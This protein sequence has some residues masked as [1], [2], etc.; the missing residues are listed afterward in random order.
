MDRSTVSQWSQLD[1]SHC[2]IRDIGCHHLSKAV[3]KLK[4]PLTLDTVN[5]SDNHLTIESVE[6]IA[7]FM[8]TCKTRVLH[9]SDNS[10]LDKDGDTNVAC[11]ALNYAFTGTCLNFPL[12]VYHHQCEYVIYNGKEDKLFLTHLSDKTRLI[13]GLFIFNY[14]LQDDDSLEIL[15]NVILKQQ[16]LSHLYFWN[17]SINRTNIK[18]IISFMQ[19]ENSYKVLF[20]YEKTLNESTTVL[21]NEIFTDTNIAYILLSAA[22]LIF[23]NCKNRHIEVTLFSN[24]L[25]P[26]CDQL[27]DVCLLNC[28]FSATTIKYVSTLWSQCHSLSRIILCNNNLDINNFKQIL[29]GLETLKSLKEIYIYECFI[30]ADAFLTLA[31]KFVKINSVALILINED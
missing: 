15:S 19:D 24:P 3:L 20:V 11:F 27:I 13:H 12:S 30:P 16:S 22:T 6:S 7:Y 23:H 26:S 8:H 29:Y 18:S 2:N 28:D 25:L 1:L 21:L 31:T 14:Q 9:V 10:I 17:C 5:L 4:N